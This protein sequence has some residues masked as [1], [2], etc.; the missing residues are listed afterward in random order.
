MMKIFVSPYLIALILL[1]LLTLT[2]YKCM[3]RKG[4][5]GKY[6]ALMSL[7]VLFGL[8][9]LSTP[10]MDAA[11][12][13][14]LTTSEIYDNPC[15]VNTVVVLSGGYHRSELSA[16]NA[17]SGETATRVIKGVEVFKKCN[18]DMIIMSGWTPNGEKNIEAELM[19]NLV[20]TMGVPK[21]KVTVES[22][23]R[24]TREHAMYLCRNK[25]IKVTDK[26]A[27]I[28]S[29][30]HLKRAL[31]EF[32]RYFNNVKPVAAYDTR[33]S[34]KIKGGMLLPQVGSLNESVTMLHEY[35]GMLWY[36]FLNRYYPNL[37]GASGCR[38]RI[39]HES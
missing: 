6:L 26:I 39:L 14:S 25:Y 29:P 9:F 4:S 1:T 10:V 11:L 18:A 12:S 13:S 21:D 20:I 24:N 31:S 28:S 23:S 19:R 37:I 34:V 38:S 5:R 32:L 15:P 8:A 7:L 35:I 36:S 30:W 17:L 3:S 16:E 2:Q 27:I 33:Y 22:D